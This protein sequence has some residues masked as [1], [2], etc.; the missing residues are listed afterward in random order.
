M[1]AAVWSANGSLDIVER[2][3]PEPGPGMLRIR[4]GAVGICGTDLHMKHGG[5]IPAVPG[6]QPGHEVAGSIDAAGDNVSLSSGMNVAIEPINGCGSCMCC[7]SGHHNI[8]TGGG[9]LFGISHDGGMAEYMLVHEKQAYTL[10]D[11]LSINAAALSEPMAVCVRAVRLAGITSGSRVAVLGA[12]TIGL[13][14]VAAARAAGAAEVFITARYPHQAELATHLGATTTY[15]DS[16]EMISAL[17][18]QHIHSVI[19]TVGGTANTIAE[20]VAVAGYGGKIVMLGL[21]DG[22]AAVP[23]LPFIIKELQLIASNCYG[24]DNG[25]SDFGVA[26]GLVAKLGPR[27]DPLLTHHFSLAEVEQA[28]SAAGDK[29]QASV[30]VQINP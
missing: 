12:G 13:L 27:L 9:Q 5:I 4:V 15:A 20:A 18:G 6:M 11:N 19:E 16:A 3:I 10:P 24:F 2:D 14:T 7:R 29:S 17:G 8:C 28:F 30:K 23:G 26:V 22:N 1:R 21:F 25:L